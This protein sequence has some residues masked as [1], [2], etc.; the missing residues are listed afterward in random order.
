VEHRL[1]IARSNP[2]EADLQRELET[3]EH[4]HGQMQAFVEEAVN[5]G[6]TI[7]VP[8]VNTLNAVTSSNAA[9][10]AAVRDRLPISIVVLL[11]LAAVLSMAL[12]GHQQGVS[13]EWRPASAIGFV[14]LVCMVLWVTLDLNQPHGGSITVSQEPMQRLLTT[15]QK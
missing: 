2:G 8:L 4:L 9:R 12:T 3:I 7:V 14:V 5:D 6:T 15:M 13:N 11:A 10:L 1:S